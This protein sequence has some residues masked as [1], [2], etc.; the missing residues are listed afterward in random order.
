MWDGGHHPDPIG[1][2]RR[3]LNE[4]RWLPADGSVDTSSVTVLQRE[5]DAACQAIKDRQADLARQQDEAEQL[6]A[7]RERTVYALRTHQD[8]AMRRAW[9]HQHGARIR[10]N[11]NVTP[12]GRAYRDQQAREL[13][14]TRDGRLRAIAEDLAPS[15][16]LDVDQVEAGLR[17]AIAADIR[18]LQ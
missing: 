6:R 5:L 13:L 2:A 1:D 7:A 4:Q 8:E 12:S 17:R 9:P 11:D 10:F 3:Y 18:Y 16:G 15:S 14:D